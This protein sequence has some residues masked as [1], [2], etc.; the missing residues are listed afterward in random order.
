MSKDMENSSNQD[1]EIWNDTKRMREDRAVREEGDYSTESM[2]KQYFIPPPQQTHAIPKPAEG[3]S[4]SFQTMKNSVPEDA[5]VSDA[6]VFLNKIKEEYANEMVTYDNFLETMRDFKFGKID[7]DE[8]CKAVRLLFKDKPHLIETFNE[9][10]PNHLKFTNEPRNVEAPNRPYMHHQQQQQ[11]RRTMFNPNQKMMH[12]PIPPHP[13]M[14][15]LGHPPPHVHMPGGMHPGMIP[16]FPPPHHGGAQSPVRMVKPQFNYHQHE[17]VEKIKRKQANNYI[18]KVKKRYANQPSIYKAFVELLQNY[19]VNTDFEKVHASI[20][21]LLWEHPDLIEEFE[22]DFVFPNMGQKD[23]DSSIYKKIAESLNE[24]EALNDFFR[25]LNYYNQNLISAKDF[26]Y[27]VSPLITDEI[28]TFKKYIKYEEKPEESEPK[29]SFVKK[30]GSYKILNQEIVNDSQDPVAREVINTSCV[31]C[32]TFESEDANFVFIKRNHFEDS[33]FKVEE[34][35]HDASL[36]IERI[37]FLITSLEMLYSDLSEGELSIRDLGMSPGIVKEVLRQIYDE[38]ASE[39]LEGILTNPKTAIPVVIKRLYAVNKQSR[40]KLRAKNKIWSESVERVYY[41]ALDTFGTTFRTN[42]KALISPKNLSSEFSTGFSTDIS[43]I[44]CLQDVASLFDSYIRTNQADN[45]K[46]NVP[47]LF[48]A[49]GLVFDVLINQ[50]YT[51]RSNFDVFCIFRLISLMY[52]RFKEIKKLNLPP[53]ESSKMAVDL[54]FS[55]EFKYEDR[56][57]E[58]KK[59]VKAFLEKTIDSATYEEKI[60]VLT[61]CKGY[62]LFGIRKIF[63]KIEK[64]II[65]ALENGEAIESLRNPSVDFEIKEG[66]LFKIKDGLFAVSCAEND[67]LMVFLSKNLKQ[68][69]FCGVLLSDLKMGEKNGSLEP[70][71]NSELFYI[72]VDSTILKKE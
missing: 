26:I 37:D 9:Y 28:D 71:E 32:P 45:K 55:Q 54:C 15:K 12:G 18:Q 25:C 33:L 63:S 30:I 40:E 11:F 46:A 51:F 42:D 16:N 2:S 27:M 38:S 6:M 43:D 17:E 62:K 48:E 72:S 34:E 4:G 8:V 57:D 23:A 65:G 24:K 19:Q 36:I 64:L 59:C 69:T 5:E 58:L 52:E 70:L 22:K 50:T 31:S 20:K 13:M 61:D 35:R 47:G 3:S 44:S 1:N 56:Y 67:S 60:R 14:H 53:L 29:G 49:V 68:E 39:V 10:L 21:G 7:A 66:G 41:K